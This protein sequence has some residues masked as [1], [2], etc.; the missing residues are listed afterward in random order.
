MF[1]ADLQKNPRSGRS[2]FGLFQAL[3]SQGKTDEAMLVR[4]QFDDAWRT[5]EIEP[6]LDTM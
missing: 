1:R 5:A 2:L 4:Q 6:D 3:E